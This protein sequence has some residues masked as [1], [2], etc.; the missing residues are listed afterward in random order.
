MASFSPI[1]PPAVG[2]EMAF[3]LRESNIRLYFENG[4][5]RTMTKH[6]LANGANLKAFG[7][8]NI[9]HL[10][11]LSLTATDTVFCFYRDYDLTVQTHA[12]TV[13]QNHGGTGQAKLA[14]DGTLDSSL[15]A[16][17]AVYHSGATAT[18]FLVTKIT[19]LAPSPGY[20]T[21]AKQYSTANVFNVFWIGFDLASR[22]PTA[23][24]LDSTNELYLL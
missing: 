7:I 21:M 6:S 20:S 23:L 18:L 17:S 22:D 4:P 2:G 24:C 10:G 9:H 12:F 3:V 14:I 15:D 19:S 11:L 1:A 5:S 13:S 16:F 8:N